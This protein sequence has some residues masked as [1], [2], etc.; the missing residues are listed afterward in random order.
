MMKKTRPAL[1]AAKA[2]AARADDARGDLSL[3]KKAL[4]G[5]LRTRDIEATPIL[6]LTG[7]EADRL[8][9]LLARQPIVPTLAWFGGTQPTSRWEFTIRHDVASPQHLEQRVIETCA[10]AIAT[11]A[12]AKKTKKAEIAKCCKCPRLYLT[13]NQGKG[14]CASCR[15]RQQ[16]GR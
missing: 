12:L 10:C 4:L 11:T 8:Q 7:T 13:H 16:R 5:S 6:I 1:V 9:V 15:R 2:G 3:L 14:Q